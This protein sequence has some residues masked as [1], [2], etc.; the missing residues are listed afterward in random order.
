MEGARADEMSSL[1]SGRKSTG[2]SR[3]WIKK[4][5]RREEA[6]EQGWAKPIEV[7]SGPFLYLQGEDLS[8]WMEQLH[9]GWEPCPVW[10][11]KRV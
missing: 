3:D 11:A 7:G 4:A 10:A 9:G 2:W 8:D 6:E 1:R 5:T